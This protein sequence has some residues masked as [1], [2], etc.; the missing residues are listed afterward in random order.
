ML[1]RSVGAGP[2]K[3]VEFVP[4]SH[5]Y[6][7]KN[8]HYWDAANI[9]I[10]RFELTNISD[11]A[12]VI[13]SLVSGAVDV[14]PVSPQRVEEAKARGLTVTTAPSL[15]AT[16][17]MVNR[18]KPPF[19]DPKVAEALRYAFDRQEL[20]KTITAGLGTPTNQPFPSR[21]FA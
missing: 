6:F 15:N 9:H 21:Y 1:F 3:I 5:A 19:N 12:T 18:N 16:D 8:P 14:A 11:P 2:F 17:L 13:A 20:L 7:V 4:E 10:D